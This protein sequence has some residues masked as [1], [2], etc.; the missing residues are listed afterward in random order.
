MRDGYGLG[1]SLEVA[2]KGEFGFGVNMYAHDLHNTKWQ[3]GL[4]FNLI[5]IMITFKVGYLRKESN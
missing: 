3:F 2:D 1:V 5:K 4:Q